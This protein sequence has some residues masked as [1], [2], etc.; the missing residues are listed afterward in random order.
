MAHSKWRLRGDCLQMS[1]VTEFNQCVIV[2]VGFKTGPHIHT[3]VRELGKETQIAE[4]PGAT[5]ARPLCCRHHP[6]CPVKAIPDAAAATQ[7]GGDYGKLF[8]IHIYLYTH[9]HTHIPIYQRAA[10]AESPA[11]LVA[12]AT[13]LISVSSV[14]VFRP[15][16]RLF[17]RWSCE[18]SAC[19]LLQV[20][21]SNT[22]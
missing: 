9:T 15:D 1:N 18:G 5:V 7:L 11:R 21:H 17:R 19:S 2:S 13:S 14:Y 20:R 10:A 12:M 4:A 8:F 6:T 22:P 16:P 3:G